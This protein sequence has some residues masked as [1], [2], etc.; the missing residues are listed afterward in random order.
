MKD[1]NGPDLPIILSALI[2]VSVLSMF[3]LSGAIQEKV[4]YYPVGLFLGY[5]SAALWTLVRWGGPH[6]S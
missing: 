5:F 6:Q 1:F 3:R 2:G 4:F